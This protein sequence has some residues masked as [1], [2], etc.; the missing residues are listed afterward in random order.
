M[1]RP[2]ETT[3]RGATGLTSATRVRVG[4]RSENLY[5]IPP[6]RLIDVDSPRCYGKRLSTFSATIDGTPRSMP[7]ADVLQRRT[8]FEK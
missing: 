7:S 6:A 1:I 8:I 4:F 2:L 5:S 3:G